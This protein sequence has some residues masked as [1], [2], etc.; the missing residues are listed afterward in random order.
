MHPS[1]T[2]A[3]A[4]L[5]RS[6]AAMRAAVDSVPHRLRDHR[7]G[8]D[9]WSVAGVLE[10]VALVD[11]RFTAIIADKIAQARTS[12]LGPEQGA[13][14]PLPPHVEGMLANRTERREAPAPVQPT[15]LTWAAAWNLSEKA[16]A[17]FRRLLVDADGLALSRV[18]HEHPRFG[19]LSAYQW[20]G[21][22]AGHESRHSDQVREIAAQIV[23]AE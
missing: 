6:R 16:R 19:A 21:F 15:G 23:A 4:H 1:L 5:D 2:E 11:A 22:L 14:E 7:P 12:D 8:P 3:F 13:P 18:I 9:R 17:A 20:A 10:H